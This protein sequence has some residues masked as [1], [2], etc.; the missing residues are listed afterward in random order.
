MT[1]GHFLT[2][3]P[4]E[5]RRLLGDASVGRVSWVSSNGLEVLPVNYV[6]IGS[7]VVFRVGAG[8]VLAQLTTPTEVAFEVDDLDQ[9]TATGWSV[10]VRGVSGAF[11]G[12]PDAPAPAPW[13]PGVRPVLVAVTPRSWS[14]R[15]VS[16]EE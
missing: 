15:A 9:S 5:C 12:S 2:I 10:L 11:D 3:D 1:V 13:A 8:S 4:D 14:G 7:Q 16:A 6:V